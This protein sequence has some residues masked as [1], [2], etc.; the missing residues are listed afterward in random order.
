MKNTSTTGL[1][2]R[3]CQRR[4]CPRCG[5][6]GRRIREL[7]ACASP[8]K[9]KRYKR[10]SKRK[11]QKNS[12][13]SGCNYYDDHDKKLDVNSSLD[14]EFGGG[15]GGGGEI[16]VLEILSRLPV[17]SLMRFK[18]V[19]KRWLFLIDKDPYFAHLHLSQAIRRPP[20]LLISLVKPVENPRDLI[21]T[22]DYIVSECTMF[23]MTADLSLQGKGGAISAAAVHTT[24]EIDTPLY[25]DRVLGPSNLWFGPQ[26]NYNKSTGSR[27]VQ[28]QRL[29]CDGPDGGG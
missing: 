14:P 7:K 19:C 20:S 25:K 10:K 1:V 6:R 26:K 16:V 27:E 21:E 29:S 24:R 18:C 13:D 9:Y 15:G 22:D 23:F 17:K 12:G 5:K 28:Q 4:R 11:E 3:R 2:S 8:I